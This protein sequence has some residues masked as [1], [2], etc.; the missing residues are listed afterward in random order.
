MHKEIVNKLKEQKAKE[1]EVK[2]AEG[3]QFTQAK[4]ATQRKIKKEDR[5]K[6]NGAW[7]VTFVKAT[8]ERFHSNF[9]ARPVLN[10]SSRL[11]GVWFRN[12]L[13]MTKKC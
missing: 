12:H 7:S 1:R 6:F 11:H 13:C 9:E 10:S 8:S 3:T 4:Q 2:R 5:T